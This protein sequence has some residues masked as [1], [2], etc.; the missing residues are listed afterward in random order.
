VLSNLHSL[1]S[2]YY[3]DFYLPESILLRGI[4]YLY[5]C[6]YDEM[7]KTLSMFEKLYQ[8][9]QFKLDQFLGQH[10]DP[11]DYFKE[12]ERVI[13]NFDD[14]K[15]N[16]NARKSYKIPFIIVRALMKEGDFK[17]MYFYIL[18]LREEL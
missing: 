3:D 4:V 5:I 15:G 16:N 9:V 17:H 18:K 11:Y 1:H 14:L 2:P 13:K 6:Q 10:T 7:E 8:P 12:T